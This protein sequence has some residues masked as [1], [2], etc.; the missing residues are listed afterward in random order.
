M[1]ISTTVKKQKDFFSSGK[2]LNVKDRKEYLEKL[3]AVIKK[4]E[5]KI[6]S[7][8]KT[9]LGKPLFE[10]Y[11][12][13]IGM[14]LSNLSHTIKNIEKWSKKKSVSSPLVAFPSKSY[15][16]QEPYGVVLVISPWN[17]PFLLSLEPVIGAIAAG[18]CCIIKPS[19]YSNATSQVLS[20]IL[21]EVFPPD[22]VT[23]IQGGREEN[24]A[25]LKERFDYI[26]FTGSVSVGKIVMEQASVNLTPVTLELGGKS[27][28][29]VT[30][31]ADLNIAAKRIAFGKILNA[32]QTCVAPDYVLIDN[33]V[34]AEF[35]QLVSQN[36]VK[37]LGS[38]S[39]TNTDFG[40]IISKRHFDRVISLLDENKIVFGGGYDEHSLKIEPT[41]MDNVT[42]DDKVMGQE[43]FGPILPIIGYDDIE[44]AK[45]IIKSMEKPLALYLF[46]TDRSIENNIVET[47]SF[48]GGCVNNTVIH[49]V[50]HK[51]PFGGIGHSGM[52]SYHGYNTF[53]TFSHSKGILKTSNRIDLSI[54][55]QPYR[56]IYE[57]IIRLVM[58]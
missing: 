58:R 49:L 23:C 57:K 8:L 38:N 31:S 18:N 26:F 5:G 56:K 1:D 28:C 37:M 10:G 3:Y 4:S 44:Q 30:S 22:Y 43:I 48:G 11:M 51:L 40:K 46:T 14:V 42:L 54:K 27:P 20:E 32:G 21:S 47:V 9:D 45:D 2:T 53:K 15:I 34:K 39:L 41:I 17:Y 13:E 16:V 12:S 29:I 24:T 36:M 55:Y 52:G 50:N 6:A 33:K 35:I 25:L 19:N 7:A